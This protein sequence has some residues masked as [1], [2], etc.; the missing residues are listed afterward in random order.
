MCNH[1]KEAG[2][3]VVR[4]EFGLVVLWLNTDAQQSLTLPS[5]Q[6]EER[7]GSPLGRAVGSKLDNTPGVNSRV[8]EQKLIM[9]L[10]GAV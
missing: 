7:P 3:Q 9:N 8:G 4:D 6:S 5:M 10:G 2:F 1:L